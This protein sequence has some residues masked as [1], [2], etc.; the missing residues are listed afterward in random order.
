MAGGFTSDLRPIKNVV[1]IVRHLLT[2][3]AILI[4]Q[5]QLQVAT[6]VSAFG[7]PHRDVTSIRALETGDIVNN[8]D[9]DE[10][11][12]HA[13]SVQ[14]RN[15]L[16][17]ASS[18]AMGT[19]TAS[20]LSTDLHRVPPASSFS[21]HCQCRA[22]YNKHLLMPPAA[23]ALVE[24]APPSPDLV[25][26]FDKPRNTGL[27][28]FF[29]YSMSVGMDDY[30]M[31][32]QP[33]KTKLFQRLFD[34][35]ASKSSASNA[36]SDI[37]GNG[38][39]DNLPVV[40]EIGMGTFPNAPY[41]AHALKDSSL[42]GLD[43]ISVDPNDSMIGYAK[44][45]AQKSGLIISSN[46]TIAPSSLASTSLRSVHGVAEA[47]PFANDSVDAIVCTL[48]LCSVTNPERVLSEVRRVLKP[49]TGKFLFWEHVLSEDN[50]GLALQQ[51]ILS[52]I[53]TL[54][55]DGCHLNRRTGS[56][57]EGANFP[58]GV[59]LEYMALDG[60]SIISPTV[61]GIASA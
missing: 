15:L 11:Y 57:I 1:M 59:E 29:S 54:V 42:K 40:V 27:D 51:Q 52:P 16:S 35:L 31:K 39:W 36:S 30:E 22:Y 47:L 34:S 9:E 17:G 43:I 28:E 41:Y 13:P 33:Y 8:E 55:A 23:N 37:N 60:S 21:C 32:A 26:S 56:I 58:G 19:F 50:T 12:A 25:K 44:E 14:R 2:T 46:N 5:L 18:A 3:A 6:L 45:S 38:G 48:T 20:V 53:Q 61:F 49:Q 4:L 10:S 7:A 24:M